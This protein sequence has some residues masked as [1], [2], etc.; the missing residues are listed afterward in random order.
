MSAETLIAIVLVVRVVFNLLVR[1]I[2]H[3]VDGTPSIR[4]NARWKKLTTSFGYLA[5]EKLLEELAGLKLPR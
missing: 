4:D 3:A 5:L 2:Q 1:V